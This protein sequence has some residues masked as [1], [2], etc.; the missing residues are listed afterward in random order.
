VFGMLNVSFTS[1]SV[2]IYGLPSPQSTNVV[3]KFT[4]RFNLGQT[5]SVAHHGGKIVCADSNG[6]LKWLYVTLE[7]KRSLHRYTD[8][9]L[10]L[11]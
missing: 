8:L 2:E 6:M 10:Y 5:M 3:S 9:I 7:I 1:G 11:K 4:N